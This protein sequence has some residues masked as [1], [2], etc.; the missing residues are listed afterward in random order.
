MDIA[1]ENQKAL[2]TFLKGQDARHGSSECLPALNK[3]AP[4]IIAPLIVKHRENRKRLPREHLITSQCVKMFLLKAP[5]KVFFFFLLELRLV[6][7]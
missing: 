4:L 3:N 2:I 1:M 6:I 5:L 7:F